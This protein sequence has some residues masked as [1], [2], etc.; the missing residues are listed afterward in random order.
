VT[1]QPRQTQACVHHR[2]RCNVSYNILKTFC[3]TP[4]HL[5]AVHT[6]DSSENEF[7]P[8]VDSLNLTFH[9]WKNVSCCVSAPWSKR[10]LMQRNSH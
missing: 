10:L 2:T 4:I 5:H 3:A 9:N 1:T 8:D 7:L 6:L